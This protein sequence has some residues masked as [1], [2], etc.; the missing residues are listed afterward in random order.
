[1]KPLP[2][3]SSSWRETSAGLVDV[4]DFEFDDRDEIA[5][6]EEALRVGE[7]GEGPRGIVIVEAGVEDS[8]DAEAGVFGHHAEGS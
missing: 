5:E 1:M 8:R 2:A 3:A 6:A 7:A 4:V